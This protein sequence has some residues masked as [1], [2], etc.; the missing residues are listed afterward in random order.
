[1]KPKHF[2]RIIGLGL[3]PAV[4]ACIALSAFGFSAS[5][6]IALSALTWVIGIVGV[7]AY[8]IFAFRV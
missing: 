6:T 8:L 1:M 2:L 3:I 7:F 4:A 5:A